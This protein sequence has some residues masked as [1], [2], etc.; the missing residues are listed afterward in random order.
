MALLQVDFKANAL[1]RR[2]RINVVLPV[3]KDAHESWADHRGI[4][5][6]TLYLL[7][8]IY[9]DANSWLTNSNVVRYAEEKNLVVVMPDGE[10]GF[11]LDHPDYMNCFSQYVGQEL[12]DV[13]RR[14][15]PLSDKREDTMIGGFSMGGYGALRTGLKFSDTFGVIAGLSSALI[16]ESHANQQQTGPATSAY[17]DAMFGKGDVVNSDLNPAFLI[18]KLVEEKAALPMLYLGCGA[19]DFLISANEAFDALL[20]QLHVPHTFRVTDGRHDWDFWEKEIKYLIREWLP[21]EN[22]QHASAEEIRTK[23]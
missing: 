9:G 7:H 1:Q 8:G 23:P 21:T 2:V 6:K 5:Y 11:Y 22:I 20:T 14:M 10:N 18:R 4:P 17:M 12:V 16:L 19:Q 13:T 3:D 15:F